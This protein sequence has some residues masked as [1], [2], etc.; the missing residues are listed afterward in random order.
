MS[1]SGTFMLKLHPDPFDSEFLGRPVGK[2]YLDRP[3]RDSHTLSALL[4]KNKGTRV[5]C[6]AAFFSENIAA[7]ERLHFRLQSIRAT[8]TRSL[9]RFA[10]PARVRR[11]FTIL[12]HSRVPLCAPEGELRALARVIGAHGRYAQDRTLSR[13]TRERIYTTWIVNSLHHGYAEEVFYALYGGRLTGLITLKRNSNTAV[14]DLLGVHSRYQGKGIG[15]ALVDRALRYA[16]EQ[17]CERVEVVTSLEHEEINAFYQKK[18]F[19]LRSVQL[20]YQK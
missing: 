3:I 8:Y 17:E 1:L 6:F 10:R 20:I 14:I 13:N 12:A 18:G 11:G 2:L 4:K 15:G 7:L 5:V 19:M 9:E 16:A